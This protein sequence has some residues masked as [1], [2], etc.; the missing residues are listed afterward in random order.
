MEPP[1]N[2]SI[3]PIFPSF[4]PVPSQKTG[5]TRGEG[6][7]RRQR[8]LSKMKPKRSIFAAL[9]MRRVLRPTVHQADLSP[10]RHGGADASGAAA[11]ELPPLRRDI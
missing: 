9:S 4:R 5:G 8:N 7:G 6:I 1:K 3:R 11:L 2:G 10:P